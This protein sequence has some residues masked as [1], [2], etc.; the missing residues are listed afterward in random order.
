MIPEIKLDSSFMGF[1]SHINLTG[2]VT[3]VEFCCE[4]ILLEIGESIPLELIAAKTTMEGFFVELNL[5]GKS[6]L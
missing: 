3:E 1:P 5:Q 6:Q 4:G 2:I